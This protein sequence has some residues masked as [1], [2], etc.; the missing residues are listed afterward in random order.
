MGGFGEVVYQGEP[1]GG[2]T[3]AAVEPEIDLND[4]RLTSEN[5]EVDVEADAY[6]VPPPPADGKW[7]VKLKHVPVKNKRSGQDVDYMPVQYARMNDGKPYLVMNVEASLIDL[8][9]KNDG[10]KITQYH[11]KS[12]ADRSGTSEMATILLKS[13]G[14]VP[15]DKSPLGWTK[16]LIQHLAGEPE[17]L[18]ETF[19]EASCQSCQEAADKKGEKKPKPFLK[20]AHR[21][22]TRNGKPDPDV[23][24]PVCGSICRAQVRIAQ[25][26]SLKDA[27]P[28]QGI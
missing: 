5:I 16:A 9:G 6:A 14:T 21:F 17:C 8:T 27:K 28:S 3:E 25:F 15:A 22:P 4:P 12:C 7:R 26:F 10:M 20:G 1:A 13:G 23:K 19:W 2:P 11:V 24:C 18:L